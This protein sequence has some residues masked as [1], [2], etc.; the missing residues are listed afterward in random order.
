MCVIGII[1]ADY[2]NAR[3]NGVALA[4]MRNQKHSLAHYHVLSILMA[5][6]TCITYWVIAGSP[7]DM[8]FLTSRQAVDGMYFSMSIPTGGFD[9]RMLFLPTFTVF[10]SMILLAFWSATIGNTQRLGLFGFG[11]CVAA[12]L[13][14]SIV[15]VYGGLGTRQMH[16][17]IKYCP[18]TAECGCDAFYKI[19]LPMAI[20]EYILLLLHVCATFNIYKRARTYAPLDE[21]GF[22]EAEMDDQDLESQRYAQ[23]QAQQFQ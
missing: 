19:A 21:K 14:T 7:A 22:E 4:S 5:A 1:I 12:V 20:I 6:M 3:R 17:C 23:Q 15:V 16:R 2:L 11:A 18:A 8:F 13:L 9:A 10:L